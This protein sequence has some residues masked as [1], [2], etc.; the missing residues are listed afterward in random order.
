MT[1][2]TYLSQIWFLISVQN[3]FKTA[4]LWKQWIRRYRISFYHTSIHMTLVKKITS[5]GLWGDMKVHVYLDVNV[6]FP[7]LQSAELFSLV[8]HLPPANYSGALS[9]LQDILNATVVYCTANRSAFTEYINSMK[10]FTQKHIPS[11]LNTML[12]SVLICWMNYFHHYTSVWVFYPVI[13]CSFRPI[14][15]RA[16]QQG[17]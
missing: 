9:L 1:Q 15:Q 4:P 13:V 8:Q 16:R 17:G 2:F 14:S 12:C 10:I 6:L 7:H 5:W 11:F 3:M